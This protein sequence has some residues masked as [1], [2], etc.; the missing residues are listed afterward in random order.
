MPEQL[1]YVLFAACASLLPELIQRVVLHG[2]VAICIVTLTI[3]GGVSG[4]V[5]IAAA[6]EP[7]YK[8]SNI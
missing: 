8:L 4:V 1:A 3:D 7:L 5:V 6:T 2:G